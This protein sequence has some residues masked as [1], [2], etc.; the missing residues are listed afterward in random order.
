[1]FNKAKNKHGKILHEQKLLS[2]YRTDCLD[3]N[4]QIH[5]SSD[6]FAEIEDMFYI[7]AF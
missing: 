6:R 2:L 5:V 3:M 1:M 4:T 7:A